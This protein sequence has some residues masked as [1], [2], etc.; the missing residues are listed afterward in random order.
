MK[1]QI[2]II[3]DQNNEQLIV[4]L[5]EDVKFRE[6]TSKL[7]DIYYIEHL[8]RALGFK[9]KKEVLEVKVDELL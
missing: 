5:G 9:V 7:N 6:D 4:M 1:Q 8:L 3:T 2:T